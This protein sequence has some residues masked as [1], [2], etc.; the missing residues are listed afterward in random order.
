MFSGESVPQLPP[1][2]RRLPRPQSNRCASTRWGSS[3]QQ[4]SSV[5]FSNS[6]ICCWLF[7]NLYMYVYIYGYI[8]YLIVVSRI[9]TTVVCICIYIYVCVCLTTGSNI[10]RDREVMH[11]Y[12][13]SRFL[14][15]L[16]FYIFLSVTIPKHH[17]DRL[18]LSLFSSRSVQRS[19]QRSA[20]RCSATKVWSSLTW[21]R[22][23][24][25]FDFTLIG[26]IDRD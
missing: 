22:H 17:E 23:L 25:Q 2:W 3:K 7:I 16:S 19:G 14:T 20:P 6:P 26:G 18:L 4:K 21:T 8:I 10:L 5:G 1:Q 15:C 9:P 24:R 12:S 11:H 13:N